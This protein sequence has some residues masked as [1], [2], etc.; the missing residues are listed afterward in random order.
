MRGPPIIDAKIS[1]PPPSRW[2]P[3]RGAARAKLDEGHRVGVT[4]VA[5][6]PGY[7]KR[8]LVESWSRHDATHPVAWVSLD[9][10]D[11]PQR[12]L[13]HS[14]AAVQMV[15]PDF[16]K[17]FVV[18][19][20]VDSEDWEVR[21]ADSS[22]E[23]LGQ[24]ETPLVLVFDGVHRL[25]DPQ[26]RRG[27]ETLIRYRPE[28]LRII[29]ITRD[30]ATI[31]VSSART[32]G[33]VVELRDHDL[34]LDAE[35]TY[36]ML[37]QDDVEATVEEAVALH[38]ATGG[39]PAGVALA[40]SRRTPDGRMAPF[41]SDEEPVLSYLR[42]RVLDGLDDDLAS[43]FL[44]VAPL[45]AVPPE[46]A[47]HVT[48][49]TD[50]G[51][52]LDRLAELHL[53]VDDP[54][55]RPGWRSFPT[56]LSGFARHESRASD[57][58]AAR[59]LG[60]RAA[61]WCWER[62][63]LDESLTIAAGTDDTELMAEILLEHHYAWSA[64]GQAGRVRHWCAV[65]LQAEPG[66]VEAQL[67]SAWA[68]LFLADDV[69][70]TSAVALLDTE[71]ASGDRRLFI[72]GELDIIRSHLA[73]RR[74]ELE[75]SL[76]FARQGAA[77]AKQIGPDFDTYYR[78]ALPAATALHVGLAAVWAGELDEAIGHLDAARAE[79]GWAQQ[80][81]TA[82]H[83]HLAVAHW[84][85]GDAAALAHATTALTYV[86]PESLGAGDFTALAMG[87]ILGADGAGTEAVQQATGLAA[88]MNEPST[89]VLAACAEAVSLASTNPT[90][91]K[92]A[93]RRARRTA[94][95]CPQP[96]FLKA[97]VAKVAAEVGADRDPV[98]GDP[99]TV[100]EQ[101]VLRMLGGPLTE[102]EIAGELHLSHNTVRTYRRRLYKKLGLTSRDDVQAAIDAMRMNP[103][104]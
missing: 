66:L 56:H 25:A 12:L 100:G 71:R 26:S 14:L 31:D 80:A 20:L 13:V 73:R 45:G 37:V 86:R 57:E 79:E 39:W 59:E 18:G 22:V 62:E 64:G 88:A 42:N 52:L 10:A 40:S 83:G 74:G 1:L 87:V 32:A 97:I 65:L 54:A 78:G 53:I 33:S 67:A 48:G 35:Q 82:I 81:Y 92:N 24:L 103:G 3:D 44:Q 104:T 69:A 4:V 95:A 94:D 75:S 90:G 70:A 76:A 96:G 55:A 58:H 49:R 19:D 47:A 46:L 6:G 15:L 28:P 36:R 27:L 7:L 2:A 60:R 8:Q 23:A 101:R 5:A 77:A 84:L 17:D 29:V 93:V 50:A 21:A 41:S 72:E 51:R 34:A 91:A 99:L 30:D 16:A 85:R 68:S 38:A 102:R 89:T 61:R 63:L 98:Y 43:F 9:E 11:D